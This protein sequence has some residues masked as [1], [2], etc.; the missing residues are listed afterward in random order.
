MHSTREGMD[1]EH[2]DAAATGAPTLNFEARL[3]RS[4]ARGTGGSRARAIVV[5]IV[6]AGWLLLTL[7]GSFLGS[8][9]PTFGGRLGDALYSSLTFLAPRDAYGGIVHPPLPLLLWWGRFFGVAL[10]T[11]A[12]FWAAMYRSRN[13]MASYLIRSR[14]RGHMVVISADGFADALVSGS[15]QEG[16][17]VVLVER[18]VSSERRSEFA[19]SG[20]IVMPEDAS[21]HRWLT[22]CRLAEAS[23]VICWM[24]SDS[25]S[26]SNAFAVRT[27]LTGSKIEVVVR[28]ESPEM[29][30]SLRNAPELLQSRDGRLRPASPTI[31]AV[32]AA[33]SGAELVRRAVE[34]KLERVHVLLH[35]D[36]AALGVIA[37]TILQHNWSI[38]LGAPRVSWNIA[39]DAPAWRDWVAHQYCFEDHVAQIFEDGD[40]PQIATIAGL[41]AL[42]ADAIAA[43]VVDYGDD[44]RTMAVAL[45]L[46]SRLAQESPNPAPVQAILRKAYA[47]RELLGHSQT[48]A[49]APPILVGASTSF[50]DFAPHKE[51][52]GGARLH[53]T[54]LRQAAGKAGALRDWQ[55]LPE[56]YVHASG[57]A[58]DHASI[59]KFDILRAEATGMDRAS[60]T[61]ALAQCE[62]R[63]WC[64]ERLLDG[65]SPAEA[66]NNERRLHDSL[67]AWSRLSRADQERNLS[68]LDAAFE[69]ELARLGAEPRAARVR[70]AQ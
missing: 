25:L 67:V 6:A 15:A 18:G 22:D 40:A 63:R 52:P 51:D 28:L 59:K 33:L 49:F 66:R 14:A 45:D 29:Q 70:A 53:R 26:L 31:S 24:E 34:L 35:G 17:C 4:L 1:S 42:P 3:A 57:A 16:Q 21:L 10:S 47:A 58:S 43:H 36:T 8:H 48:L 38:H 30:R 19:R 69:R 23:V 11:I 61:E 50:S 54:Y 44:D 27:Q 7:T 20:V 41:S 68:T 9:E 32:R 65:W 12:I 55:S 13:L 2:A 5:G 60:L 64:V 56:T 39:A 37:S 46:A 62:H